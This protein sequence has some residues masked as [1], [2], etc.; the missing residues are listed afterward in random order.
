MVMTLTVPDGSR[1]HDV[2]DADDMFAGTI[3]SSFRVDDDDMM[4][5]MVMPCNNIAI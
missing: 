1:R 4:T 5:M 2:P 3:S